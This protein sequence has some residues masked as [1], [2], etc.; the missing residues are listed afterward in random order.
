MS[1]S[2]IYWIGHSTRH[3]EMLLR[4]KIKN[5]EPLRIGS[6]VGAKLTSLVDLPV[7]K[8]MIDGVEKPYIPGSSLKG[9]F[10]SFM[11]VLI[12]SNGGYTCQGV[13]GNLCFNR[14]KY[15]V[16]EYSRGGKYD[17]LKRVIWENYCLSCKTY[18]SGS[19]RSKVYFSDFFPE[20]DVFIG[21][22]PGVGID[23]KTGTAARGALYQVEFVHPGALFTGGIRVFD[24]S[25]YVL[26]IIG[27][28]LVEINEGRIKIG[29]FKSRGFGR[30]SIEDLRIGITFYTSIGGEV[31][32]DRLLLKRMDPI[33]VDVEYSFGGS[34]GAKIDE[35]TVELT[36]EKAWGLVKSIIETALSREKIA[37]IVEK[38]RGGGSVE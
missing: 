5:I 29:G 3:R 6:G 4:F 34:N 18:G 36:G 23:R 37:E 27:L 25:N 7:L 12:R 17:E 24:V 26:G 35:N 31:K 2:D 1:A 11:D 16:E 28:T 22:K 9:V 10:R 21:V 19:Y 8:V 33:D 20:N 32:D 13:G 30:V 15:Y 14:V 38:H